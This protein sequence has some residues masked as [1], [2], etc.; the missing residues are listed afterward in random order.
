MSHTSNLPPSTH[1][2]LWLSQHR[3]RVVAPDMRGH[4]ETHTTNDADLS[5]EVRGQSS[6]H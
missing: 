5:K 2:C 3:Y 1:L 4:G 6:A